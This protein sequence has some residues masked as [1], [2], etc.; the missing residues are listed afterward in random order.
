[1]LE[2]RRSTSIWILALCFLYIALRLWGLTDSCLWFDE[3]FSVHAA[4]HS[5]TSNFWFIAQDLIHPPLF[6]V[7]LKVW[8]AI[9]GEGLLW[10][11]L[12]P[13]M[14]SAVALVPFVYLCRELKL[15]NSTTLFALVFFAVNGSLIKY[16]QEVRMYSLLLCLSLFSIWLFSRYFVKGKSFIPLLIVNILLVYTHYFGWFVIVSEVAAIL[17][18]QRMKWRRMLTM[19]AITFASFVPWMIAVWQATL[20]GKGLG[21]NIGWMVPPGVRAIAQFKLNLTEPFYYQAS[22]V[23]P[24][25]MFRVSIPILLIVSIAIVLYIVNWKKQS[26]DEKTAVYFLG[27]F[28]LLPV[29]AALA[30][31]WLLPYSIWGTRHLIIVFAPVAILIAIAVTNIRVWYVRT[32]VFTLLLLFTGYGFVMQ[33]MSETPNYQWCAWEKLATEVPADQPQTVYVFEDLVAYHF[34]FATRNSGNVQVVKVDGMPG[35]TEDTAYFLPR[36]FEAVQCIRPA[37]MNSNQFWVAFR[38]SQWNEKHPPI[39]I[40]LEQGFSVGRPRSVSA[41]G[42]NAFVV[43]AVKK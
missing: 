27:I 30:V 2:K 39:S 12:F 26:D 24:V 20:T 15:K 5:W 16:A 41:N 19:F 25:S 42:M 43:D 21:Q 36:G 29:I 38:D 22:T 9:G 40:L 35:M 7:L 10:L 37:E 6:Y 11:R 14:F 3:I 13:V 4:E 1:M 34:W 33:V 17:I 23:D 28:A 32:I 18:F 31:S 8:I